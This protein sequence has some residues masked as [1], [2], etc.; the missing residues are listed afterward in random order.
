MRLAAK[1]RAN[2]LPLLFAML[3]AAMLGVSFSRA[4]TLAM[5]QDS[6]AATTASSSDLTAPRYR[7]G[8]GDRVRITVFGAA[9]LGGDFIINDAGK[10]ALPLVGEIPALGKSVIELQGAV[11]DALRDGY[12]KEPRV[13]IE[14]TTYRPFY[15]L[16]EVN[17][18]GEYPYIQGQTVLN[19]V[20]RA[21]GFTYRAN[22]KTYRLKKADGATEIKQPLT[23]TAT[24]D[25][26]DT[27]L[28][29]ERWF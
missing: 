28:I 22:T 6:P 7:L 26:G 24:I 17:K 10:I 15:I 19:A 13:S 25:P 11:A 2:I 23:A 4:A 29:Q 12:V 18:P 16:G 21:Q 1:V 14:V 27:I 20:A 3:L 9:A 5:A 8:A